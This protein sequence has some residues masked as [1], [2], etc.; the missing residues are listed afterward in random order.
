MYVFIWSGVQLQIRRQVEHKRL[1]LASLATNRCWYY[2]KDE[3]RL[4]PTRQ[5][6]AV[7]L[8]DAPV[9]PAGMHML[10]CPTTASQLGV[11]TQ[12]CLIA[13]ENCCKL[14]SPV[15]GWQ[16]TAHCDIESTHD[17]KFDSFTEGHSKS[18]NLLLQTLRFWYFFTPAEAV[19]IS[20][21][22][23]HIKCQK[24][25]LQGWWM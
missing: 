8:C 7:V 11:R 9:L 5:L 21:S 17:C 23:G 4:H 6:H 12:L 10:N 20:R 14:A 15:S 16:Q 3:M 1:K 19:G 2:S 13:D 22:S 25:A 18:S 24:A